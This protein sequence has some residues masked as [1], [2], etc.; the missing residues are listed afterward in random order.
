MDD[1]YAQASPFNSRSIFKVLFL[2]DF[3]ID[4]NYHEGTPH[5]NCYDDTCCHD[6]TPEK[7]SD[8]DRAPTYGTQNCY[9]PIAGFKKIIDKINELNTTDEFKFSSIIYGGNSAANLPEYVD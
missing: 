3:D 2:T 4:L 9:L 1:L 5:I 7:Q 6:A 8:T